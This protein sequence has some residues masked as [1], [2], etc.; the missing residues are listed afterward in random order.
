[1]QYLVVNMSC[2]REYDATHDENSQK[3]YQN[4]NFTETLC[5]IEH[6][7]NLQSH[8]KYF[9]I[10]E[11]VRKINVYNNFSTL[12]NTS[13]STYSPVRFSDGIKKRSLMNHAS[14][15]AFGQHDLS[16]TS[17]EIFFIDEKLS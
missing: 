17:K 6:K 2:W 15:L 11:N 7:K 9:A 1:M 5:D 16:E 13:S 3:F 14:T 4:I 8:N 10:V 12:V